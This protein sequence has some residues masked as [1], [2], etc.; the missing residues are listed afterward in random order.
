MMSIERYVGQ[1]AT[2]FIYDVAQAW[3]RVN[4]CHSWV[5]ERRRSKIGSTKKIVFEC[6]Y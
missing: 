6:K 4:E 1:S 2:A 3:S 5:Y